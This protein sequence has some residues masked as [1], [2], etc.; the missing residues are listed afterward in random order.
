MF[1]KPSKALMVALRHFVLCRE[2]FV[3]AREFDD[4]LLFVR[5]PKGRSNRC[6]P[7]RHFS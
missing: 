6:G 3:E 5:Q 7:R 1:E 4:G 2:I